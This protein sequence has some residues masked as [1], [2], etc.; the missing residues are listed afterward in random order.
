MK[1]FISLKSDSCT[2]PLK[3]KVLNNKSKILKCLGTTSWEM[4]LMQKCQDSNIA[5]WK[6]SHF[7]L[8]FNTV[9]I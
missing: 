1:T 8:D 2:F 3:F 9:D 4:A 5:G 6:P 7:A